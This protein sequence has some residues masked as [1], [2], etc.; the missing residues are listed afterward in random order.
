M[1]LEGLNLQSISTITVNSEKR[2]SCISENFKI[3]LTE[4]IKRVRKVFITDVQIPYTINNFN[5][6]NNTLLYRPIITANVS[7][8]LNELKELH[9]F[10][11]TYNKDELAEELTNTYSERYHSYNYTDNVLTGLYDTFPSIW[12]WK[13]TYNLSTNQFEAKGLGEQGISGSGI[14]SVNT[15]VNQLLDSVI[16]HHNRA[17][18]SDFILTYPTTDGLGSGLQLRIKIKVGVIG[19]DLFVVLTGINYCL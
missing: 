8:E 10:P 16:Q 3:S 2:I 17:F 6:G 11:G 12:S 14:I 19:A 7:P 13:W 9:L 15:D 5:R 4:P 18:A 1:T